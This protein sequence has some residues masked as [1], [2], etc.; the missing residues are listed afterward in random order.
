MSEI[1]Q[2]YTI[3]NEDQAI[4][5]L[6]SLLNEK[7]NLEHVNLEF[8][9][10]PN[11]HL[12][13]EGDKYHQT[14]T[15]SIMNGFLELQSGIYKSY[16]L[17]KYDTETTQCLTKA[18]R[19]ELE[20]EVKVE[21]GSSSFDINLTEIGIKLVESTAGKMSPTQ[22]VVII[23]S[24]L[25]LYFGKNYL[26]QILTARKEAREAELDQQKN[27]EDRKERLETIKILTEQNQKF[28][29]V[30]SKA[31]QFDPRIKKMEQHA[32]DT[33]AA[34]LKSVQDADQAE[35][36]NAV[37]LPGDVA[38][39]LSITPKTRWEPLRIDDWYRVLEVDSSN[40]A[41]RKIRLQR[42]KDNKELMSVLENDSLDQKNLQLIQQAEWK[43]AKIFLHIETLT[44]NGRYKES[45]IIGAVNIDE[46]DEDE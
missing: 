23:L 20:I 32:A 22:A 4:D 33:N 27:A 34:I 43:Y 16:A 1:V 19:Q 10:W 21:D 37:S 42:I 41:S 6:D 2:N 11:Y 35:I 25:V 18:E 15:P 39:E 5:L 9:G 44:L 45:R 24:C 36:Q 26:Q 30:I 8:D 7:L 29:D 46:S 12:H 40:A 28:V 3:S 14:I 38:K 31:N 13:V 17:I